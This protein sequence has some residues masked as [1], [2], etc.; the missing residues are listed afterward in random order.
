MDGNTTTTDR[1]VTQSNEQKG[2]KPANHDNVNRPNSGQ[3]VDIERRFTYHKPTFETQPK[4]EALRGRA[5]ELAYLIVQDVPEGSEQWLA[6][7]ALEECTMWGN[8]GIARSGH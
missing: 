6:L 8:A 1:E 5:K 2:R 4:F 7:A 3:S